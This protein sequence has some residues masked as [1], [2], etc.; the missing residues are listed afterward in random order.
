MNVKTIHSTYFCKSIETLWPIWAGDMTSYESPLTWW[1]VTKYK[2][3]H[4]TIEISKSLNI[5]K[6]KLKKMEAR[7]NE[8]KDPENNILKQ[9]SIT[10]KQQIKEY[11]ENQLEAAKIR[12]RIKIYEEGEKSSTFVFNTEKKNASQ[13]I[14]KKI[15]CQDGTYSSNI[16]VILNE[17]KQFYKN[18]FTSEGSDQQESNTL[19]ENVD[20]VLSNDQKEICDA[21]ISE[22]KIKNAI[23]ILKKNKSP[24]DDGI[25]S[26]FYI[27]YWYLIRKE[28]TQVI[29]HSFNIN[30]LSPSQYNAILTLL[31][32]KGEREDIRNWR[33]ISLLNVDYKI[34]TKILAERLKKVLPYIIHTDQKGF[35][36]GR[37]IQEA[38]RLLQDII[39]YTDQYQMNS[40]II[41]LDYENA[42][43]RVEWSWT[44]NCLKTFNF[45]TKFI[46]WVNMI[47]KEAKTSILTNGFRSTY[48]R[49][50]RSMRQGCP[51]SPLLFI[52]QAEPLACAIRK[53][54]LSKVYRCP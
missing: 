21:D 24:G 44:L 47:F 22:E 4:L 33:P 48:F 49:I 9:E 32:K 26:E 18:L 50:S 37:N 39:S 46:S 14:W 54:L 40:A 16:N 2:I 6:Y 31:Y 10:L 42:F 19:L 53:I 23:K 30:T 51:V 43:D 15:K 52:L 11:Y 45:G 8:I 20:Q 34:I 12:S 13:R 17:Q 38:N 25:V 29:K 1:E 27:D 36:Q 35:V 28:F 7:L 5:T 3:E 41:F